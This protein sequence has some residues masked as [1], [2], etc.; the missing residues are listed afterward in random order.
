MLSFPYGKLRG[1]Y[2]DGDAASTG[3]DVVTGQRDLSAFV[4][5]SSRRQRQRVRRYDPPAQQVRPDV[6]KLP[7]RC[8]KCV[9]FPSVTPP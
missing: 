7:S 3:V 8:S 9:G 6:Q 1:V 5:L 4:E 2:A